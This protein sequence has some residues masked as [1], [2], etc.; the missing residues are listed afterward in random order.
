M[1]SIWPMTDLKFCCVSRTAGQ[2]ILTNFKI[3]KETLTL[4]RCRF[5]DV[6][7]KRTKIKLK[8]SHKH[9]TRI[10]ATERYVAYG[11]YLFICGLFIVAINSP[12]YA[13]SISIHVLLSH[14]IISLA[15][16]PEG[17]GWLQVPLPPEN[18]R[19]STEK[20]NVFLFE[21]SHVCSGNSST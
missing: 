8:K 20:K 3:T 14:N 19:G 1:Q 13:L 15:Q 4:F 5:I 2:P 17:A 11:T 6:F 7:T 9:L 16:G 18:L 21:Y 12:N 10:V